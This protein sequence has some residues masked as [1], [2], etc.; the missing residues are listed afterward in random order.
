[1]MYKGIDYDINK[2]RK[3]YTLDD[4]PEEVIGAWA[5]ALPRKPQETILTWRLRAVAKLNEARLKVLSNFAARTHSGAKQ[6][7]RQTNYDPKWG[8]HNFTL[9][10]SK[11]PGDFLQPMVKGIRYGGPREF[12]TLDIETD[13]YN[14]PV[15]ISALKQVFNINTK[16]FE[17]VAQF[18]RFYQAANRDLKVTYSTHGLTSQKLQK[19]RSQYFKASGE[20][21]AKRYNKGEQEALREF[22]GSSIVVGQNVVDFD[23][24]NLFRGDTGNQTIDIMNAARVLWPGQSNGLGDI[25]KRVF[26]VSMEDAGLPHH[27]SSSDVIATSLITQA[28]MQMSNDV[29]KAIRFVAVTPGTH[30]TQMDTVLG[31]MVMKGTYSQYKLAGKY[32]DKD[33][34]LNAS[35]EELMGAKSIIETKKN[36]QTGKSELADVG[37]RIE[38]ISSLSTGSSDVKDLLNDNVQGMK[39]VAASLSEAAKHT[40]SAAATNGKWAQELREI[41][42]GHTFSETRRFRLEAAHYEKEDRLAFV[43][44]AGYGENEARNI[45]TGTDELHDILQRRHLSQLKESMKEES[46]GFERSGDFRAVRKIDSL[47]KSSLGN[48][49]LWN[50]KKDISD[51]KKLSPGLFQGDRKR[52]LEAIGTDEFTTVADAITTKMNRITGAFQ[53]FASIPLYNFERL[54]HLFKD[55]VKGVVGAARGIVPG[56]IYNPL[57][58]LTSAGLNA[59]DY[60]YAPYKAIWHG[61]QNTGG[62]LMGIGG[63][64]VA[65]GTGVAPGLIIAGVGGALGLGSQ[66]AGLYGESKITRWGEGLQNNL[67][68]LGFLQDMVLMPFRTL[69]FAIDR[70]VKGFGVL[71]STLR[72]TSSLMGSGLTSL[73]QMGNPMTEMTGLTYGGYVGS[74]SADYASLLGKGTINS[75]LSNNAIQRMNMYEGYGIDTRRMTAASRLGIFTELYGYNYDEEEAFERAINK[76]RA[77]TKSQTGMQLKSTYD[78]LSQ[79]NPQIGAILQ[80]M[81]TLDIDT[82]DKLKN[83]GSFQLY[84]NPDRFR[85]GFQRAQWEYQFAGTQRDI[86]MQRI[87]TSLWGM[88][89]SRIYGGYN[90]VLKSVA[91]SFES[92]DWSTTIA[93]IKELW[94]TFQDGANKAWLSIKKAFGLDEGMTVGGTLV[95]AFADIGVK[96][97]EFTRDHIIPPILT[98]W[99]TIATYAIDRL[100]GIVEFLSTIHID[101]KALKQMVLTGKSD[102][103][104]I[105]SILDEGLGTGAYV[106]GEEPALDKLHGVAAEFDKKYGRTSLVQDYGRKHYGGRTVFGIPSRWVD[107]GGLR[108][109]VLTTSRDD[110]SK[111]L[112]DTVQEASEEQLKDLNT[113]LSSIYGRPITLKK[114]DN[115]GGFI[116][117]MIRMDI[118]PNATNFLTG[119]KYA[120]PGDIDNSKLRNTLSSIYSGSK[121]YRDMIIPQ[122]TGEVI[123]ALQNLSKD[124][125]LFKLQIFDKDGQKAAEAAAHTSGRMDI[126]RYNS[127]VNLSSPDNMFQSQVH[128]SSKVTGF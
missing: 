75:I 118:N 60:H 53:A 25:F 124:P 110:F 34:Y 47:L 56:P 12:T 45:L 30:L 18:Q 41:V 64:L 2:L 92:G 68:T 77:R 50:L 33:S 85:S 10:N 42:A 51:Y 111:W 83:P 76:L 84:T 55:E 8:T 52:L 82:Y 38:D 59:L 122:A 22:L 128:Q 80:T 98:V 27:I 5:D 73:A 88:A 1:M 54:E 49:E 21:L 11:E 117:D 71:A 15:T 81:Q 113:M 6:E 24:Y 102:T 91:D 109:D 61:L 99:D 4:V 79:V 40:E 29:G 90:K 63:S 14:K 106:P 39:E 57:S 43:R 35:I 86:S 46:W 125:A 19:L 95:K 107:T 126:S 48:R 20:R 96:L 62:A 17:T 9:Y 36:K 44:A 116:D 120:L 3:P 114:G 115:I 7:L 31:S 100:T 103:P 28:F 105:T 93:T 67:N 23:M 97:T 121:E 72:G 69:K 78:L 89:G 108:G 58:R 94:K 66:I 37:M 16:Q 123:N 101:Y 32:M 87:A 119:G 104:W 26:G 13:D 112:T 65:S 74:M 70:V 127:F